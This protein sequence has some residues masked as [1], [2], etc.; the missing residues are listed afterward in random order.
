[1]LASNGPKASGFPPLPPSP[2]HP[3]AHARIRGGVSAPF[4]AVFTISSDAFERINPES[5]TPYG[6][7]PTSRQTLS[8][9]A[10][11]SRRSA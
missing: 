10:S 6:S 7:L 5:F 9:S 8:N 1:M 4:R 3:S 2:Q 11:P